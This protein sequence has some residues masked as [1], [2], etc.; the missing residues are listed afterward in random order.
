MKD[1]PLYFILFVIFLVA[2]CGCRPAHADGIEPQVRRP[3][4]EG[5]PV[6]RVRPRPEPAPE[7][8]AVIVAPVIETRYANVTGMSF[9]GGVG[10]NIN[11]DVVGGGGTIVIQGS[12]ASAFAFASA[13]ASA[14]SRGGRR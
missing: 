13:S 9:D 4:L 7:P 12:S 3:V 8:V 14:S 1:G 6:R 5:G 2:V 10:A 11:T